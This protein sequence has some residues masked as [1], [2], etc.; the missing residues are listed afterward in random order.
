MEKKKMKVLR[1]SIRLDKLDF[2]FSKGEH[3]DT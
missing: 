1:R 2:S 3:I